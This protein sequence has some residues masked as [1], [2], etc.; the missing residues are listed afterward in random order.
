MRKKPEKSAAI[1]IGQAITI[2]VPAAPGYKRY[3]ARTVQGVVSFI[4]RRGKFATVSYR[5][6]GMEDDLTT[7]V[8]LRPV[9]YGSGFCL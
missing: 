8:S 5:L 9:P 3:S 7:T 4:N 1:T 6:P 2:Q